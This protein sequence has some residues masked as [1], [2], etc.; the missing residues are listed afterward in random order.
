MILD[1]FCP[2]YIRIVVKGCGNVEIKYC[3]THK[4]NDNEIKY[5]PIRKKVRETIAGK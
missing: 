5:L 1:E 4:G 3:K 2:S